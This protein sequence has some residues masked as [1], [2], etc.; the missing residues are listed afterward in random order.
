MSITAFFAGVFLC[1]AFPHLCSGLRG[2]VFPT[3]FA[4]PR[5][6]GPSSP[7]VNFLWGVFNLLVG[8]VLLSRQPVTVGFNS[9]FILLV[10]GAL[11]IGTYLCVHF[12]KVR[13]ASSRA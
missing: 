6:K 5:G 3:P 8:I 2:E 13:A 12:G 11:A 9:T 10:L 7:L 1:N 4:K